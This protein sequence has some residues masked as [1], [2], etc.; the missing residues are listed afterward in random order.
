L[1]ILEII[2]YRRVKNLVVLREAI[3]SEI[4][5]TIEYSN[6]FITTLQIASVNQ[7]N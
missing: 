1:E 7:I 5:V 2:N 6:C 3:P 4:S